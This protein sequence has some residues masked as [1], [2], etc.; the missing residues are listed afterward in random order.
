MIKI[1]LC[2]AEPNQLAHYQAKVNYSTS[3]TII[4]YLSSKKVITVSH[5]KSLEV[6]QIIFGRQ[7]KINLLSENNSCAE[8]I[9]L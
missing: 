8:T 1:F 4:A 2:Q 6:S 9:I 5:K 7:I 3:I